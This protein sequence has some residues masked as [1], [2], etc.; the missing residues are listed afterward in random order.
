LET[1]RQ[2]TPKLA[3]RRNPSIWSLSD[4]YCCFSGA[5]DFVASLPAADVA[6]LDAPMEAPQDDADEAALD[7][8]ESPEESAVI[9][10]AAADE[11]AY[12]F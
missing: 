11:S 7:L 4:A 2:L 12:S 5:D 9:D 6:N 3:R 1:K 10:E 8:D